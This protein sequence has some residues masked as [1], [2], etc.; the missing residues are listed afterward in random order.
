MDLVA[1]P[2]IKAGLSI[3][4]GLVSFIQRIF[5]T[6]NQSKIE[7]VMKQTG[8][9]EF[10]Y[11]KIASSYTGMEKEYTYSE[12]MT[13]LMVKKCKIT[14]LNLGK[15][16]SDVKSFQKCATF[17]N[18][19]NLFKFINEEGNASYLMMMGKNNEKTVDWSFICINLKIKL[20]PDLIKMHYVKKRCFKVEE[21]DGFVLKPVNL[22][23]DEFK[24]I[25]GLMAL[26]LDKT[27]GMK[28]LV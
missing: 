27:P 22:Q 23:D 26:E 17:H 8:F 28:M 18:C 3:V 20:A 25:A 9:S 13:N 24:Y 16:F 10:E 6:L 21:W 11:E 7:K 5:G 12:A 1:P 2:I 4:D 14:K 15:F 19:D